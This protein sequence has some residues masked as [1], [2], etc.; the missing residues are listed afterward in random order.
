MTPKRVKLDKES[1]GRRLAL[2]RE[3]HEAVILGLRPDK[4]ME[5]TEAFIEEEEFE[6]AAS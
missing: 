1:R 3:R 4:E 6:A 2:I 5:L